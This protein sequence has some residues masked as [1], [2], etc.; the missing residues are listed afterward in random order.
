MISRAPR[1]Q[2]PEV[3]VSAATR[4]PFASRLRVPRRVLAAASKDGEGKDTATKP[5]SSAQE[6]TKETK[7][8]N[9]LERLTSLAGGLK[10]DTSSGIP[11]KNIDAYTEWR[12]VYKSLKDFGLESVSAEEASSLVAANK[13]VILDVRTDLFFDKQHAEPSVNVPYFDRVRGN[14]G[15]LGAN[16]TWS[17]AV[18]RLL[19]GPNTTVKNDSFVDDVKAAVGSDKTVIVCCTTGGTIKSI[20]GRK[21]ERED[22]YVDSQRAFGRD[23]LSLRA[24]NDLIEAG[25]TN[26]K[27]LEGGL[28]AWTAEELPV[29]GT[30]IKEEVKEEK[31]E[32][33]EEE[34]A[35]PNAWPAVHASLVAAEVPSVKVL[36][37]FKLADSGAAMIV[38]VNSLRAYDAENI[39]DSVNV[40]FV[41]KVEVNGWR[42]A[43]G[44]SGL[45]SSEEYVE[46]DPNFL[47]TFEKTGVGKKD[48]MVIVTCSRGGTLKTETV[49][50]KGRIFK[51]PQLRFGRESQSLRAISALLGAGY[52]NV[53]HLEGGNA[54]WRVKKLPMNRKFNGKEKQKIEGQDAVGWRVA[55]WFFE[56]EQYFNGEIKSFDEKSGKYVVQFDGLEKNAIVDKSR[57]KWL[58]KTGG[59][60]QNEVVGG[61]EALK[62]AE[63]QRKL[64][65]PAVVFIA[66]ATSILTGL[67]SKV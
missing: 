49:S 42:V 20:F 51:D 66:L 21:K 6:T 58:S 60:R 46:S 53:A 59:E 1:V 24:A 52:E 33:S 10:I 7:D 25:L 36:D 43:G 47:S 3:A 9:P 30:S 40:P 28:A 16:Q 37:A 29:V 12:A 22:S 2:R 23:S 41:R 48:T 8:E 19:L 11:K 55:I 5:T 57:I 27:H 35:D 61:P 56:L 15:S 26:V 44:L 34:E 39:Q 67:A 18:K 62:K 14:P 65:L 13:A 64:V 31:K 32:D 63:Q 38:D 4:R 17:R 54:A 45:G 50:E